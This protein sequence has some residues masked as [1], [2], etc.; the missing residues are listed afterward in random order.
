MNRIACVVVAAVVSVVRPGPLQA[1]IVR[2][3]YTPRGNPTVD[4]QNH[5]STTPF[6]DQSGQIRIIREFEGSLTVYKHGIDVSPYVIF[7]QFPSDADVFR[8]SQRIFGVRSNVLMPLNADQTLL[9]RAGGILSR[10][11]QSQRPSRGEFSRP[12][13]IHR[14]R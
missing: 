10:Q 3:I 4:W 9:A 12:G 1:E 11:P 2:F 5:N 13:R 7:S 14:P 8:E 6:V